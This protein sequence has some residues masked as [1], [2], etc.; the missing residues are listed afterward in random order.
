[1]TDVNFLE[2]WTF[3]VEFEFVSLFPQGSLGMY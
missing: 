1:L 3:S 2:F